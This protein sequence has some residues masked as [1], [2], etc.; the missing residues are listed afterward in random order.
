MSI[1]NL[2]LIK[3]DK[4]LGILL[5]KINKVPG[6]WISTACIDNTL[7]LTYNPEWIDTKTLE[8]VVFI[9]AH[10][11]GHIVKR[12]GTR[13]PVNPNMTAWR[14]STDAGI[15]TQ[16][17]EQLGL[18][19]PEDGIHGA[20]VA[21]ICHECDNQTEKIY[22]KMKHLIKDHECGACLE[23]LNNALRAAAGDTSGVSSNI[24]HTCDGACQTAALLQV[25]TA[26]ELERLSASIQSKIVRTALDPSMKPG[27]IP[28]DIV[29]MLFDLITP[30]VSWTNF[31][32]ELASEVFAGD[33]TWRRNSRRGEGIDMRLQ[34]Q[35]P[36]TKG[37]IAVIDTSGS[38]G[39]DEIRTFLSETVGIMEQCN[40]SEIFLIMH[41]SDVY[42]AAG[43]TQDSLKNM[44]FGVARGGTSHVGVFEVIE[45]THSD[46]D[47]VDFEVG[48]VI[49]FTDMASDFPE[50]CSAPV[51]WAVP[52][53]H[54]SES[55]E[56]P[57]EPGSN[58]HGQMIKV[59]I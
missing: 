17:I 16:L 28:S 52:E 53:A 34:S 37:V 29:D 48:A 26:E 20:K 7:K 27:D 30:K 13:T 10:E 42:H 6:R 47:G 22:H 31:I 40:C 5:G 35:I 41:D 57:G 56:R 21:Q 45:G 23:E 32:T 38:I 4:F 51:V 44:R 24:P 1:G 2:L 19:P 15:N 58:L 36:T 54:Y 59:E 50:D 9:L 3:K 39:E 55:M 18:T 43:Y 25:G 14:W 11:V 33:Y 46:F 12:H 49:C 8:Q